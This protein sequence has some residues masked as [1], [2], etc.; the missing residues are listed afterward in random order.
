MELGFKPRQLG[1]R[2]KGKE[3]ARQAFRAEANA[4]QQSE[5]EERSKV[6]WGTESGWGWGQKF[7][8]DWAHSA[9]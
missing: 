7:R 2:L 9:G 3:K 5:G 8:D 6:T 1:S 4:M